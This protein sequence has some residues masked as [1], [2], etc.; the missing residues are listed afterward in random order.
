MRNA[1]GNQ[2]LALIGPLAGLGHG[3][4]VVGDERPHLGDQIFDG[5]ERAPPEESPDQN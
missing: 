4:V 1:L 2:H 5:G 3:P